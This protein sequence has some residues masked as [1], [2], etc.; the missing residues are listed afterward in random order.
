LNS[1]V[2]YYGSTNPDASLL[3]LPHVGFLPADDPRILGTLAY[4]EKRLVKDGLCL[5]YVEDAEVDGLEGDEGAF[6]LCSFWL[7]DAL[8]MAGRTRDATELF[9]RLLELRND[10]GLLSEEVDLGTRRMVGNFPQ[11]FSHIGLVN[12]AQRLGGLK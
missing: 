8:A 6:L 1:F 9:E 10:V 7:A 3:V 2:Q 4:L 5:R 11:A 12:T